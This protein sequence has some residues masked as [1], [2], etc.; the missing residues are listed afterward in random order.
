M[1]TA[2]R[3]SLLCT[4]QQGPGSGCHLQLPLCWGCSTSVPSALLTAPFVLPGGNE[5]AFA[6]TLSRAL[7]TGTHSHSPL[8]QQCPDAAAAICRVDAE[9]MCAKSWRCKHSTNNG[10]IAS[11]GDV[12]AQTDV[13]SR[14][15]W[16]RKPVCISRQVQD[17]K[18]GT[19]SF[20]E[21][22]QQSSVAGRQAGL[23]TGMG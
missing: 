17:E 14:S 2:S 20:P 1:Q 11:R 6:V 16:S 7:R 19:N 9:R 22:S 13:L 18:Q 8:T 12:K 4:S 5:A 3:V 23:P 10:D 15:H 21:S